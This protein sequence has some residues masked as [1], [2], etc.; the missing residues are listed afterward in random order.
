[1]LH[2]SN[3]KEKVQINDAEVCIGNIQKKYNLSQDL[4]VNIKEADILLLPHENFKGHKNCFP[5]QT[6]QFYTFLKKEAANNN[7]VV[8]I[9][10]SDEE[11]KELEL[12]ADVVNISEILIQW[13]L[14]PI[15]TGMITSYLYD[16]FKQRKKKINTFI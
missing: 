3:E 5:E 9:A 4:F 1:M 13:I 14:F 12:H 15:V 6:Y 10:S 16:I 8:D 11:Y 2:E 7:L